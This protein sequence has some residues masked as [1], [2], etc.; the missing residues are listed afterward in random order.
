MDEDTAA[1]CEFQNLLIIQTGS[2]EPAE[3]MWSHH[4]NGVQ[5][6]YFTYPL[7]IECQTSQTNISITAY[8]DANVISSW[9]VQRILYQFDSILSQLN[10]VGNVRDIHVFSEQ[11][12]QFVSD[13]RQRYYAFP[14]LPT[15]VGPS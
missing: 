7:V 12:A 11:D 13:D 6:Q 4:N 5:G 15:G 2:E 10:T 14:V 1:A 8:Y 3:S 9:E